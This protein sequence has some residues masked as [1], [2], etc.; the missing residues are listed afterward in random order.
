MAPAQA[1]ARNPDESAAAAPAKLALGE[2]WSCPCLPCL[3]SLSLSAAH[4]QLLT[5]PRRRG[6][7]L[8]CVQFSLAFVLRPLRASCSLRVAAVDAPLLF[9]RVLYAGHE[10]P[11][12]AAA[13]Q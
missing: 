11:I 4:D 5:P 10:E 7:L 1:Q 9:A 12:E 13:A 3:L 8:R 6:H 2:V